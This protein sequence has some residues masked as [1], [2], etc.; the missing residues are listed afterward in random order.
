MTNQWSCKV[1]LPPW[2]A[3]HLL[4]K[5]NLWR[6]D[7]GFQ[8]LPV[9]AQ[10]LGHIMQENRGQILLKHLFSWQHKTKKILPIH[11]FSTMKSFYSDIMLSTRK[12][13]SLSQ[14]MF[15][16]HGCLQ[17]Y[18]ESQNTLGLLLYFFSVTGFS[19]ESFEFVSLL[20]SNRQ[21]DVS[22][23]SFPPSFL[24]DRATSNNFSKI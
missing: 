20:T 17:M 15:V 1:F 13:L 24:A 2:A 10:R 16:F 12:A 4:Q 11:A 18:H 9:D 5:R 19:R 14:R 3:F 8:F 7:G 21:K 22:F 6:S 23:S